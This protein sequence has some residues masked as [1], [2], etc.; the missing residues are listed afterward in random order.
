MVLTPAQIRAH[1]KWDASHADV[2]KASKK[3][4]AQAHKEEANTYHRE[5][6]RKIKA[7]KIVN[8]GFMELAMIDC[9]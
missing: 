9:F 5:Y 2:I 3:R 7:L 4:Y 8:T 6:R 1:K